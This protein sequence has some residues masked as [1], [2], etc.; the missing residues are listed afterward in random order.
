MSNNQN[1]KYYNC[2]ITY[3][4][5][6]K[7][8]GQKVYYCM[9]VSILGTKWYFITQNGIFPKSSLLCFLFYFPWLYLSTVFYYVLHGINHLSLLCYQP[10]NEVMFNNMIDH[11][12][13]ISS[14]KKKKQE[15]TARAKESVF[16]IVSCYFIFLLV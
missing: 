12:L 6:Q 15:A 1:S 9:Q 16:S 13:Y 8:I 11:Q 5:F 10:K 3:T 7:I 2:T 14:R 4:R